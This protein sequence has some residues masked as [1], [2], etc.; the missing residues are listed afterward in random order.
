MN[1]EIPVKDLILQRSPSLAEESYSLGSTF[2]IQDRVEA[3]EQS[4]EE[5]C[6]KVS[7]KS[8]KIYDTPT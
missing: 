2:T 8:A 1:H 4:S 5:F 6:K 3:I 7:E